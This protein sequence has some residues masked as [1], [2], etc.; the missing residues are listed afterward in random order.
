MGFK[1]DFKKIAEDIDV[2]DVARLL[3]VQLTKDNR[4]PCCDN[5]R[6][7]QLFPDT[8]SFRCHAAGISG[9]CISLY[10]H[11]KGY[12]G[13][14]KA[15]KELAEHFQTA[16]AAEPRPTAPQKPE[17]RPAQAQPAPSSKAAPF[18]AEAYAAKLA[19]TDEVAQ[20]GIAE[21]DA[22]KLSIGFASTGLLRGRI[23]FPIRTE[24]GSIAGF[25]GIGAD[26]SVKCPKTWQYS[27]NVVK[28]RRA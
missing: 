14:Y 15:A 22:A 28:L 11:V 24:S 17:G 3:G 5:D 9:D 18:D 25:V 2:A 16:K 7:L 26:G 12:Q 4:A 8:N 23:A 27:T 13:M 6:S 20:L 21:E 1:V 10:A 19:Y